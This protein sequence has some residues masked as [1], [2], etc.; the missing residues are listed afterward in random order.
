MILEKIKVV[1]S[2]NLNVDVNSVTPESLLK[3]DLGADSLD[4]IELTIALEDAFDIKIDD[5]VAMKFVSVQD[6]KT[7]IESLN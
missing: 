3:Q 5:E 6:I 1:I 2:E 4:A 7:Y